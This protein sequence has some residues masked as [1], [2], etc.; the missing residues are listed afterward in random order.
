MF[1]KI[2]LYLLRVNRQPNVILLTGIG[3]QIRSLQLDCCI[4]LRLF[5]SGLLN[6]IVSTATKCTFIDYLSHCNPNERDLSFKH[7]NK[8]ETVQTVSLTSCKWLG[9][10]LEQREN[11]HDIKVTALLTFPLAQSSPFFSPLSP[12]DTFHVWWWLWTLKVM[13]G[14]THHFS[15][16]GELSGLRS[17]SWEE[18]NR[19]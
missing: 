7:N 18:Q 3:N 11:R 19:R 2:N 8:K 6:I 12:R 1:L 9:A 5:N 15:R 10:V 13:T 4:I 16:S 17:R 14:S